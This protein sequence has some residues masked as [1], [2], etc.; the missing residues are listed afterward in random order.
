MIAKVDQ[1][2]IES[3]R[4]TVLIKNIPPNVILFSII[5]DLKI[6]KSNFGSIDQNLLLV[7]LIF[8]K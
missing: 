5:L 2:V 7:W 6:Y 3:I 4:K 8:F 1:K